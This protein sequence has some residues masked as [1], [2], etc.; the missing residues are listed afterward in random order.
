MKAEQH[1]YG[2]KLVTIYSM[3][4]QEERLFAEQNAAPL[5]EELLSEVEVMQS[6]K[7]M[8]R[9]KSRRKTERSETKLFKNKTEKLSKLH[10]YK[11]ALDLEVQLCKSTENCP[12]VIKDKHIKELHCKMLSII[13]DVAF[14]CLNT[15]QRVAA[16]M[17]A[18]K[19]LYDFFIDIRILIDLGFVRDT[20]GILVKIEEELNI[21]IESWAKSLSKEGNE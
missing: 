7:K 15:E 4:E 18:Q 17:G 11:K 9:C 1:I 14:A 8:Y 16:L 6:G 21:Q 13:H 10:V 19:K 2:D 5:P 12:R 20:A 3:D